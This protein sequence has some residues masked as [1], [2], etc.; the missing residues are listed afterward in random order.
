MTEKELRVE[1]IIRKLEHL[2]SLREKKRALYNPPTKAVIQDPET[3]IQP[4][5]II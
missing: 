1:R 3:D 5:N 4:L 2:K